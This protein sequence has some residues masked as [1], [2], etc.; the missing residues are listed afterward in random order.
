[1]STYDITVAGVG[2]AAPADGFI[3]PKTVYAYMNALATDKPSSYV[4][5]LAKSR[6]NRRHKNV[7]MGIQSNSGMQIVSITATGSP[8]A[9]TAP[10]SIVYRVE[11]GDINSISIADDTDITNP[12]LKGIPAIKRIIANALQN[13]QTLM[14]EVLDPTESVAPGNTTPFARTG[15]RFNIETV[16]ALHANRSAAEASVTVALVS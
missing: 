6:A 10:S 5:S 9:N 2:G 7:I 12:P 1:M 15:P 8:D 14:L 16:G 4:T 13:A 3:D 11:I